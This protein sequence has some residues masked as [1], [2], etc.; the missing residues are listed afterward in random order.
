[1]R[2]AWIAGPLLLCL[3]LS[4]FFGIGLI[5][6]ASPTYDEPV[7]LAAGYT[8][9]V[10]GRYRLNAM[11][12]PP[13]GEMWAALPLLGMSLD[14]FAAHPAWIDAAVY[15]YGDLFLYHNRISSDVLLAA[16]RSWSLLT[17]TLLV[18]WF[19]MVWSARL[20]GPPG[21]WGAAVALGCC[22]PWF[23]NA[24]LITTDAPSAALFFAACALFAIP[25]RSRRTY[26]LGGT[27]V[28]AAL[29]AKFN[30]ILLPPLIVFSLIVDPR[31]EDARRNRWPRIALAVAVAVVALAAAY[32]FAYF[33]LYF[34]GLSAT[35]SRLAQGRGAYLLGNHS[36]TGWLWYYP[37][38]VLV[39]T[40]LALLLLSGWGLWKAVRQPRGEAAWLLIPPLG[41]AAVALFSKTQIGYRHVLPIYPFICLW[42]GL[43]VADLWRR[44]NPGRALACAMG[45]WAAVSVAM[46]HPQHLSY[47]NEIARGRSEQ[48]LSDSNLDWGQDLPTLARELAAR[49]NPPFV[50]CY[51]GSGDPAAYGLR[52][53][54]LGI[55]ATVTRSGNAV[56]ERGAPVLFAVS[57]TNLVGT[58]MRDPAV[59]DWLRSRTPAAIPGGSIWLYDLTQDREGRARLAAMLASLGR[60]GDADVVGRF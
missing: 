4:S 38:A 58:Y 8:D 43:G 46:N 24:A 14:R 34:R 59:F 7:H 48:W 1:M 12:H 44:A 52:Y 60:L 21:A 40:P 15:H 33:D 36:T 18:A 35:L 9:L 13:L 50:L 37:A 30:M 19:L 47:F 5:R 28:G 41:Y 51:F 55:L 32:R 56:L 20:E 49:G 53:V 16:S 54:P 17:W 3:A 39:K 23:S 45:V 2:T 25:G 57:E 29:A 42:A 10:Q 26:M 27:I 22:V 11:D 6:S 31:A